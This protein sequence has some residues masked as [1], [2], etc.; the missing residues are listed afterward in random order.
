MLRVVGRRLLAAVPLVFVVSVG[1]FVLL[2]LTPGD[3]AAA[4]AGQSQNTSL[5]QLERLREQMGLNRSLPV[6]YWEWL[7]GAVRGDLG[8]SLF[9]SQPVAT[10]VVDRLPPTLSLTFCAIVLSVVVGV[11]LG[12]LAASRRGSLADRIVTVVTA[13]GLAIPGFWL[14]L[15]LV[16]VFVSKLGWFP[17]TGYVGLTSDPVEWA[18][19]MVLPSTA[20]ALAAI[21]V[22]ARQ[23][24]SA[25]LQVMDA[26]FITAARARGLT[27]RR[28]I[29]KHGLK[30]AANPI[31]TLLGLQVLALLGGSV[32]IEQVFAIPG[33]GSLAITSTSTRDLTMVQ[34]IV[35]LAALVVV[36]VNLLVDLAYAYVNPKARTR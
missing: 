36:V 4:I 10:S 1:I 25:L 6:Q 24:R 30:N 21:G 9:S 27:R 33:L 5:E 3:P 22:L 20:L 14:G 17:P 29:W 8:T 16:L 19:R 32:I 18:R 2:R 13:L 28:A 7:Q 34:G 15:L 11:P 23:T 31:V 35:V 26:D 12:V